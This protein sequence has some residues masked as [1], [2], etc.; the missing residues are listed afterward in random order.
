MK[1]ITI[2]FMAVMTII[3]S[4]IAQGPDF[5]RGY[6]TI[7][8]DNFSQDPVG[9]LPAKWSTS[10]S[11][12]VVTL[13]RLKG[14][15]FK[16]NQPSAVS[17]ELTEA[18]AENCTI[19]FDLF[20]KNTTGMAPHIM[21]GLTSLSDVSGGDVYR[22]HIW[23]KCEGYNEEGNVT[24]G[25]TIQD[26]GSKSFRLAGY[27]G[28][29]LHVSMA[30]NKTRLRVWLDKQKVVDLPKVLTDDYRSNFFIACS[31]VI[32]AAEEGVYFSNVHIAEGDI[33]ARSLLIKQ[34]L[35]NGTPINNDI[36]FNAQ[37]N[38]IIP[39]SIPYLDT[40]GQIM[41][42]DPTMNVQINGN[43]IMT[44]ADNSNNNTGGQIPLSEEEI[45]MKVESI[46]T[47]LVDKFNVQ[48]D[49]IVTGVNDKI[50][51]KKQQ[52]KQSKAGQMI[53]RIATE[54]IKL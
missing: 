11:G 9:D 29:K 37:T 32:P 48:A 51:A 46:K 12:E 34:M 38:Q 19:E 30:I 44:P 10:G 35:D 39:E 4:A 43:D 45:K 24:F 40:I 50:Q 25:K 20:L 53:S 5:V 49:R 47:Y 27:N 15:W 28:R 3:S 13:D 42:Y 36:S 33:D 26:L 17:P 8:D 31:E 23:I 18:L 16:V 6:K 41:S 21:F 22:N 52:L 2:T 14:N 1:K 54:I 7:F